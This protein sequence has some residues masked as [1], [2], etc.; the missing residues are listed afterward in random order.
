MGHK[1]YFLTD[2]N[3][4][5]V[6]NTNTVVK[7]TWIHQ[8]ENVQKNPCKILVEKLLEVRERDLGHFRSSSRS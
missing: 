3:P 2:K 1:I 7:I 5:G 4:P 6:T 8:I